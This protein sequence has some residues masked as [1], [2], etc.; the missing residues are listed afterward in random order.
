MTVFKELV[1]RARPPVSGIEAVGVIP[2]SASF[3]SGHAATA[4]AAAVASLLED[5]TLRTDLAARGREIAVAR[6]S[7]AATYDRLAALL[8]QRTSGAGVPQST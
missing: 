1:D 6:M 4:F 7:I 5:A 8:D 2:A 3:P